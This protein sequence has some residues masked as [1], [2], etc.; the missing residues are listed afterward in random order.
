MCNGTCHRT[1]R[2]RAVSPDKATAHRSPRGRFEYRGC[3]SNVLGTGQKEFGLTCLY[4]FIRG[5]VANVEPGMGQFS[6]G[7]EHGIESS[8][9][10]A[11]GKLCTNALREKGV[12]PGTSIGR[13]L[14]VKAPR[15]CL[16]R[17]LEPFAWLAVAQV[18][19]PLHHPQ[20][21]ISPV[22]AISSLRT[23]VQQRQQQ[24]QQQQQLVFF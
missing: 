21:P 22:G 7:L 3:K 19:Q 5:K 11:L 1:P 16:P 23:C 9:L 20:H 17:G 8:T 18:A 14:R 6:I 10:W 24:Q 12:C 15:S 4:T 13:S 2:N